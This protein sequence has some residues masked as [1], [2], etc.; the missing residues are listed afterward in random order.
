M[1]HRNIKTNTLF[2]RSKR[3]LL[4]SI[5]LFCSIN[6]FSKGI[7]DS[8]EKVI[9]NTT[10][11]E[12]AKALI[13]LSVKYGDKDKDTAKAFALAKEAHDISL[14]SGYKKGVANYYFYRSKVLAA[15]GNTDEAI[16]F[17]NKCFAYVDTLHP[18]SE[19]GSYYINLGSIYGNM[20]KL[21]NSSAAYLKGLV[22]FDKIND[23]IGIA[24]SC[25]GLGFVQHT[26]G[27]MVDG[28]KYYLKAMK[29]YEYAGMQR[30][31]VSI[32]NNLGGLFLNKAMKEG[33]EEDYRKSL[34]YLNRGVS[35][36]Q[37]INDYK[38]LSSAYNNLAA[39]YGSKNELDICLEYN[40]KSLDINKKVDNLYGKVNALGNI[41]NA[42]L[43]MKRYDLAEKYCLDAISLSE[44]INAAG[45]IASNYS[46]LADIYFAKKDFEGSLIYYKKSHNL[47]DSLS[48]IDKIQAMSEMEKKYD[49]DKKD[50]EIELLNQTQQANDAEI[51]RQKILN[52]AIGIG[53]T[54][55]IIFSFFILRSNRERKKANDELQVKNN[56]IEEKNK[57]I[58]DS[59]NYAKRIQDAILPDW[60]SGNKIFP[61]AFI[62][63]KP[64]DIVSGDFYW[65]AEKNGRRLIAAVDCTGHGVPG[66]FMSMIGNAF[67]NEVVNE[68]GIIEPGMILSELRYLVIKALK[69]KGAD[70]E[71]RDGMDI[72]LLSLSADNKSIDW[73]GANN[74]LWIIRDGKIIEHKPDKR[75]IGFFM[76]KGLPFKNHTIDLQKGDALYI[77]TDGYADQFGGNKEGGKK[78]KVSRMK[79]LLLSL[80]DQ[81]MDNQKKKLEQTIT[82]WRGNLEQVDDICIIGIRL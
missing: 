67:L 73:A 12:K 50:K 59:I 51:A 43:L 7:V 24:R 55:V 68:R 30:E 38:N 60:E 42:Y 45:I 34:N 25:H 81:T 39:L 82:D 40:F 61:E 19:W 77:F 16:A 9:A 11:T 65:F 26:A 17:L 1:I 47:L 63:F 27:N 71:Q 58:T 2:I 33:A 80:Q 46:L 49:T 13:V 44:K 28:E 21:D 6:L 41:A 70:G 35:L 4:L 20:T 8:L 54:L 75:P 14:K 74:P 29:Y 37:K 36:A 62:L 3:I 31:Q 52:Y 18:N 76:G 5:L 72:S 69:Q 78:F 15:H 23:T 32:L 10:G 79:T 53:F 57:D 66:A 56:I 22:I 48:K 64:R